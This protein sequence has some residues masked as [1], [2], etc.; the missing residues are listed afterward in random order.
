VY[1]AMINM[2]TTGFR[3]SITDFELLVGENGNST[4]TAP[5][6]YYFYVELD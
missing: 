2:S 4:S 1:T 5:T 3:N 6:S